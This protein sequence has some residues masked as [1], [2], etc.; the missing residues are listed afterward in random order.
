MKEIEANYNNDEAAKKV[1]LLE[2]WLKKYGDEATYLSLFEALDSSN[3]V[4]LIDEGLRLMEEGEWIVYKLCSQ[5]LFIAQTRKDK[6]K[7]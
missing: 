6:M 3:R 2:N 5:I 4:D 7:E 1:G